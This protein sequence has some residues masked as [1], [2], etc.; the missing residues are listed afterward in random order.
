MTTKIE[1]NGDHYFIQLG[2][3]AIRIIG[4]LIGVIFLGLLS[5]ISF[6]W[7]DVQGVKAQQS[8]D[9]QNI[10]IV[11]I[12]VENIDKNTTKIEK[13]VDELIVIQKDIDII[14]RFLL[15]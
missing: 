1:K 10:E 15:R 7:S 4:P 13:K 6:L 5:W 8:L 14:K 11:K 12:R 3:F 9:K 2:T